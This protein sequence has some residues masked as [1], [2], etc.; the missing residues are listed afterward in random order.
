MSRCLCIL[1]ALILLSPIASAQDELI[2]NGG[3]E[4]GLDGWNEFWSRANRGS[5]SP[6]NQGAH[7]GETCLRVEHLG[8]RDWSV[9][10]SQRVEVAP[11]EIYEMSA[12]MR[13]EGDG[14]TTLGVVLRDAQGKTIDWAFGGR[15][16]GAS[17]DWRVVRTRFVIPHN[18]A[19]IIPRVIGTGPATVWIDDVS[20]RGTGSLKT[21]R[22]S[23]LPSR[24]S[25]TNGLIDVS[26]T[27]ADGRFS[28]KN[29]R[30]GRRWTSA[31]DAQAVV[32]RATSVE[33]G[34][35]LDL[36]KADD[37]LEV[38]ARVRLEQDAPEFV[39]E[40][41]GDGE[42]LQPLCFPPPMTTR[43]GEFLIVPVNEGI[44]YP[45]DDETLPSMRYHLYGGHGLCMSWYG[46]TDLESGLMTIVETPDDARVEIPR[47]DDRLHLAPQWQS[48]RGRFSPRRIRYVAFQHGGYVAM[49]KRYRRYVQSIG[50]FKTLAEKREAIPAV[51]LLVGAV[52]VWCWQ[53]D[54]PA[55]CRKLRENGIERIL[56]S[57]R[58]DPEPLRELNEMGV[59]C[60]RY[61]IYQDAMN[62]AEFP[63]LRWQHPDWTSD[64]WP[65]DLTIDEHGDWVRGWRVKAKDGSMIPCG[66]LCDSRA[67]EYARRR[68][69]EEL[70]THPYKTRFIDTTTASHWRECYHPEHPMTRSESRAARMNLLRFMSQECGLVT[71]SETGHDAAVPYLHYFEG[72]MSLGPYRIPDAGRR[73][74]EIVT[75][76]P[77]RVVRFQTGH[78]YRLPL[79]ELVYHDCIV[80]YW[81]WGDYNNKMPSLWDRRD[82]INTLYGTPPMFMF[83]EAVWEEYRERFARSYHT[84]APVARATGYSEMLSHQWLTDDH[85]VQ[86]TTFDNGVIVT[87]NFGDQP[88]T[89][90]DGRSL[91]P[92]S[93]RVDGL[94]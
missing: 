63:K 78:Y 54:A 4:Q 7:G 37:M 15:S 2:V 92:M 11:G 9:Q 32:L 68:V 64:A 18:G 16:I 33:G 42:L 93:H 41:D 12:A 55:W 89:M 85:A 77:E 6:T 59:L 48:Q 66:V 82:L 49:C 46:T 44:S 17:D 53:P 35:D 73:M 23:N 3:F 87:V 72:M 10:Q 29:C 22:A 31:V 43:R 65:H 25:A 21:L 14:R 60:S 19:T 20:L 45:V 94:K 67:L 69:P 38:H 24:V 58:R 40:L 52:N 39:I 8:E 80:S 84:I 34:F 79:W 5:G 50:K 26:M 57:H 62:P 75:D 28:V 30:T 91:A 36:L 86:Q 61:D 70:K 88:F 83:N 56:W 81:Y 27:T 47:L 1:L 76:P 90:A 51:D 71:G 74:Q 13:L